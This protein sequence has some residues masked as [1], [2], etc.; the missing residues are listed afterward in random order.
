MLTR[1]QIPERFPSKVRDPA[2]NNDPHKIG[3]REPRAEYLGW[4]HCRQINEF[5][6][7]CA[8]M[9]SQA[10]SC[11][12]YPGRDSSVFTKLLHARVIQR[13]FCAAAIQSLTCLLRVNRG[14]S[15]PLHDRSSPETGSPSASLLCRRSAEAD[16]RA[17]RPRVNAR[18]C[19]PNRAWHGRSGQG[20]DPLL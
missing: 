17:P 11:V 10:D 6:D 18:T 4:L 5:V 1:K 7:H 15:M 3:R 19:G 9:A 8:W 13:S 16:I 2:D 12:A 14:L 20:R